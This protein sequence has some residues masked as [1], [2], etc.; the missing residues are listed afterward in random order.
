MFMTRR[1]AILG[2][3]VGTALS[4]W[5][6]KAQYHIPQYT[7]V[8]MMITN[9]IITNQIVESANQNLFG[10]EDGAVTFAGPSE[11]LENT[12]QR[13]DRPPVS[14]QFAKTGNV[15]STPSRMAAKYPAEN[16]SEATNLFSKLL[17]SFAEIERLFRLP[18]TDVANAAAAF[19]VG[20]WMA[21][22]NA[23]FPDENFKPLVKQ[24]RDVISGSPNFAIV[25]DGQKQELY[26]QLAILGMFAANVQRAIN[27][28][29]NTQIA[30]NMRNAA[31]GYLEI[32][33]STKAEKV[34]LTPQ[35]LVID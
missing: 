18:E 15:S 14:T 8:P 23:D 4:V 29:P 17:S 16:R 27:Q 6:A 9:N 31:R 10:Q 30:G 11:P 33:L 12:T 19:V 1:T 5:P 26:E 21:F 13:K 22:N 7:G 35:G 25:T 28:E 20:S 2:M 32:F 24:L 3:G 34:K